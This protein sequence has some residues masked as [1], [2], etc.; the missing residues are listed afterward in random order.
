MIPVEHILYASLRNTENGGAET[1]RSAGSVH[2]TC[3]RAQ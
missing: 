1:C 2:C 3:H